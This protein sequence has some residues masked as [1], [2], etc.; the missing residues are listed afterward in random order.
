MNWNSILVVGLLFFIYILLPL[1]AWIANSF[2]R[3]L[4]PVWWKHHICDTYPEAWEAM[5]RKRC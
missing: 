1:I 3:P 2:V 4:C 5:D